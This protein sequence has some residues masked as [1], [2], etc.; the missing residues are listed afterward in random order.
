M[1]KIGLIHPFSTGFSTF[2]A[3]TGDKSVENA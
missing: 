2:D 1:L 3:R